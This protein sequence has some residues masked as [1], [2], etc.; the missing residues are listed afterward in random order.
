[1]KNVGSINEV[2]VAFVQNHNGP[3][4]NISKNFFFEKNILYSYGFHFPLCVRTEY[5]GKEFFLLNGD[6]YSNTTA[7][8]QGNIRSRLIKKTFCTVSASAIRA[9]DRNVYIL[10]RLRI[11]DFTKDL[12]ASVDEKNPLPKNLPEGTEIQYTK[13]GNIES[14]HRA[15]T[16]L[17]EFGGRTFL[18]GMDDGSYFVSE[19]PKAARTVN[20]AFVLLKPKKI[21]N[22]EHSVKRQGE[23]FFLEI[24]AD[25]KTVKEVLKSMEPSFSLPHFNNGN[26][27]VATRGRKAS[28]LLCLMNMKLNPNDHIISGSIRHHQHRTLKLN[29]MDNPK[30]FLAIKNTSV[31]NWS[32]SGLVD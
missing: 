32:A 21:H 17:F 28:T 12:Y 27:H 19:L 13:H 25:W 15:G 22:V 23:W 7:K 3:N 5:K 18:C 9:I 2:A 20:E 4:K 30:L 8:H 29:R 1:M 16:L 10:K 14:Y 24:K 6:R 26:P 31:N 11:I